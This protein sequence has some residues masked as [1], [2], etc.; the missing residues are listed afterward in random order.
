MATLAATRRFDLTDAE[1]AVPAPLRDHR[2][3]TSA[4]MIVTGTWHGRECSSYV[5][6]RCRCA[7]VNG[8]D[9]VI[10]VCRASAAGTSSNTTEP[11]PYGSAATT[12]ATTGTVLGRRI[13]ARST[14]DLRALGDLADAQ[15]AGVPV[16]ANQSI[17]SH[18]AL[19]F[20]LT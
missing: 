14:G 11:R 20:K 8:S 1:W 3:Y 7:I 6:V 5:N 13:G 10:L 4:P 19:A 16:E 18:S 9:S 12:P 15:S 17:V 2:L